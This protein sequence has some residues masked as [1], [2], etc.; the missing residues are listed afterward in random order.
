MKFTNIRDHF[1]ASQWRMIQQELSSH[2]TPH[3]AIDLS[4]LEETYSQMKELFEFADIFYPVKANSH[5]NILQLFV[6]LHANFEIASVYELEMVLK[7]GADPAKIIFG[8]PIVSSTDIASVYACGVRLFVCQDETTLIK[9]A[10]YAP[11]SKVFFRLLMSS[12]QAAHQTAVVPLSD[13]FGCDDEI[14]VRLI[15]LSTTLGLEPYG[16]SFHVGSQ[17]RNIDAWGEAIKRVKEIFNQ[18]ADQKITLQMINLGGGFPGDYADDECSDIATY[19]RCIRKM[20]VDNFGVRLPRVIIEPGRALVSRCGVLASSV[21]SIAKKTERGCPWIHIDA[22]VFN[23]FI[24]RIDGE[25]P[26]YMYIPG[27]ESHLQESQ[28]KVALAG[29]TCDGADVLSKEISIPTIFLEG[30]LKLDPEDQEKIIIYFLAMGAYA[31]ECA[32]RGFN[33]IPP[34]ETS[35]VECDESASSLRM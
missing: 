21:I 15:K 5:P 1:T 20:L 18:A 4:I 31:N 35:I 11:E 17:Q 12:D 3:I 28:S 23:G 22:G 33:G 2:K 34:L 9:I 6:R 29:P 16:I 32:S 30:L 26:Y 24:E 19:A 8:N 25:I 27:S 13:K 10:R 14:A 7:A